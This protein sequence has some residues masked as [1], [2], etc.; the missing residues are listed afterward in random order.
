MAKSKVF[1]TVW[2]FLAG[3]T[4]LTG[5]AG[6]G[7]DDVFKSVGSDVKTPE[8][9]A[10]I[11][12]TIVDISRNFSAGR[13]NITL[14]REYGWDKDKYTPEDFP[15][16]RLVD[17]EELLPS[18]FKIVL[19]QLEAERTGD[20]SALQDRI[21][22]GMLVNVD[23]FQRILVL[24]LT[25]KSK[26]NIVRAA[27]ILAERIDVQEASPRYL[28]WPQE[29]GSFPGLDAETEMLIKNDYFNMFYADYVRN[30]ITAADIP[31]RD[32]FG[33]YNGNAAII[34][35]TGGMTIVEVIVITEDIF[36]RFP[37]HGQDIQI[38]NSESGL[39][40]KLKEAFDL[41][42]ISLDDARSM[43]ELH[44]EKYPSMY[45]MLD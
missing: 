25:E 16:V 38:W 5:C 17:V 3:F 35:P 23:K 11:P 18:T 34:I 20:W 14:N 39:F 33:I 26:G 43:R 9:L 41:G 42:L 10:D 1:L 13:L 37:N 8:D 7:A 2:A 29:P 21:N 24:T 12:N 4:V 45:R 40:Y 44:R 15:E 30:D 27:N 22:V 36:F 28:P 19:Q 31:I 6:E 32:F